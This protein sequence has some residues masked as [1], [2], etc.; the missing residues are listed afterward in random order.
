MLSLSLYKVAL[1]FRCE[2]PTRVAPRHAWQPR[3][4]RWIVNTLTVL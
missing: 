2:L 1:I 3:S 4:T